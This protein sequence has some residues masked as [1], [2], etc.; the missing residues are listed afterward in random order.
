MCK[1]SSVLTDV[2]PCR[3]ATL[4]LF[5]CVSL[6]GFVDETW[7]RQLGGQ[8]NAKIARPPDPTSLSEAEERSLGSSVA[9]ALRVRYGVVQD[10]AIQ[11][12]VT[13]VGKNVV[14]H[15]ARPDLD[16]VFT[17]LDTDAVNSFAVPGGYVL[18]TRGMLGL[19]RDESELAG[20]LAHE[21][22]H[23]TSRLT[24]IAPLGSTVVNVPS[25]S[26]GVRLTSLAAA[27][28]SSVL[29]DRFTRAEDLDSDAKAL[30]MARAAG[31]TSGGLAS[32]L[33]KLVDRNV[34]RAQSNGKFSSHPEIRERV[35]ALLKQAAYTVER[36]STHASR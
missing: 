6:V 12:Y 32:L 13:L 7:A 14:Q 10:A 20:L 30:R 17:V 4:A 31:Y 27:I 34:G 9:E 35:A 8:R 3:R 36:G 2:S 33:T 25:S 28:Y 19:A 21:I 16:W 23:I 18:V 1:E 29:E 24:I 26:G 5:A 15:S 22:A 11:R